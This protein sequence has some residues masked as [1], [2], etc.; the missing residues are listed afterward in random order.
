VSEF[1]RPAADLYLQATADE[2]RRRS[3][4]ALISVLQEKGAEPACR[5]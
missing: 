3:E 2:E 1:S 4:L 5:E